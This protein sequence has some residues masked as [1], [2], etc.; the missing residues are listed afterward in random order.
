LTFLLWLLEELE[1]AADSF[2]AIARCQEEGAGGPS[3]S[4][5]A[6]SAAGSVALQC[7]KRKASEE[8]AK[9]VEDPLPGVL[10]VLTASCASPEAAA[11]ELQQQ[12][13]KLLKDEK[14]FTEM[15][16]GKLRQSHRALQAMA[17]LVKLGDPHLEES[18]VSIVQS[19][20]ESVHWPEGQTLLH[21]LCE[22][23]TD[24]RAVQLVSELCPDLEAR[25]GR[26]L[27]AMDYAIANPSEE[28]ADRL[29]KVSRE[30][31]SQ[32]FGF[33]EDEVYGRSLQVIQENEPPPASLKE[34]PKKEAKATAGLGDG[35]HGTIGTL[36]VL[37]TQLASAMRENEALR[38]KVSEIEL[39]RTRMAILEEQGVVIETPAAAPPSA[40]GKKE[41]GEELQEV[42]ALLRVTETGLR[43][44]GGGESSTSASDAE[45][46][47]PPPE[48]DTTSQPTDEAPPKL[49]APPRGKAKGKGKGPPSP[50][51][52]SGASAPSSTDAEESSPSSASKGK[53]KSK[54][55]TPGPARPGGPDGDKGKGKGKGK[56]TSVEPTKPTVKP[57]QDLK[58]LPWTRYV[59]GE[60]LQKGTIW[61]QVNAVYEE[62][63]V[64]ESLPLE[65]IEKR[66]GKNA[67]HKAPPKLEMKDAKKP[68]T[69]K[70]DSIS[71]QQRFQLEVSIRT[72]PVSINTG[73]RASAVIKDLDGATLDRS[74]T[75]TAEALQTL[76]KF[77]CPTREQEEELKAKRAAHEGQGLEEP[78]VWDPVEQYMEDL[79]H[80]RGCATRLSCWS[81]LYSLPDRLSTLQENLQRFEKMVHCF[82]TSAEIPF[83]LSLVLAFGNYLN[84]GK[85]EKRLG[86]ADGFHVELLGRPGGLDVV[87][88]GQG[89][90]VRQLIFS[91]YV[92]HSPGRAEKLLTELAPM[93][94]LVQ[95]RLG[96]DSQGV[97]QFRKS[98]LVQIEE[99]DKQ[100]TQLKGELSSR[101][102]ELKDGLKEI[103]DPADKFVVQAPGE[104]DRAWQHVDELMKQKDT[105][106]QQFKSVL[107]NFKAE[108]YRGDP[109]VVDGQVKDGNP[110]EEMTSEVWCKIWDDFFV[111]AER[112]LR[113]NEKK[114]KELIEPHFCK[115]AP[116]VVGSLAVLWGLQ[117][118]DEKPRR[119]RRGTA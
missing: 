74:G 114:Q 89:C 24:P 61:D 83:L 79:S 110:K 40:A 47:A 58:T 105:V 117:G 96:K 7:A 115:D 50:G 62:D 18:L 71:Q 8:S 2:H 91:H 36:F 37:K 4:F 109:V 104:F 48:S 69:V 78:F 34:E 43:G 31:A 42:S 85:N 49:L 95:R 14:K 68:K 22:H 112:V 12:Q 45:S 73:V 111:P 27:R 107:T 30:R 17:P 28:V 87:N 57:S 84:G 113:L 64:M 15:L 26:G 46:P 25:D 32:S 5:L 51:G 103:A 55:P 67:G 10:S 35:E 102:Q 90:N 72:L 1:G 76:R 100:L 65:E 41:R 59:V 33:S 44:A 39:L 93:F 66:F 52:A 16:Q 80:I 82:L 118:A 77:L 106:L 21:F 97:P 13:A 54:G 108:T 3:Y 38:E 75:I 29:L 99:L 119:R 86:Q 6:A 20:W 98:V 88:D 53:G 70:I 116:P 60:K 101:H 63:H 9:R 11:L 56:A 92:E 81:F 23:S 19:G 94:S